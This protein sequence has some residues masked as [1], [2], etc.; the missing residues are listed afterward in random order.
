MSKIVVI[1]GSAGALSAL[2]IILAS[3]P[4]DFPA[5]ILIVTH[6]GANKSLLPEILQRITSLQVRHA[7]DGE[8]IIPGRVLVAPSDEHLTVVAS[9]NQIYTRLAHGPRENNCR[10][11]IDPLFRSAA[12]ACGPGTT[13]VILSGY[14]DD[15][16]VGLQAIKARGGMAIVQDPAEAEVQEM[17]ASAI[18]HATVD[19][20]L[21]ATQIGSA[22]IQLVN[23]DL[24]PRP[25]IEQDWIDIENRLTV[26]DSDMNDLEEIGK[27]SSL[28]CPECGGALWE[29]SRPGPIRYRCHTAHAFTA[30]VLESLQGEEVEDA[31]WA[32]VRALHEQERLFIKMSEKSQQ[33]GH[34]ISSA[35]YLA[36]AE[37]A[38]KHS[39]SLREIIATRALARS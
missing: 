19:L 34:S 1:G 5:A 32:A 26:R 35:E 7:V 6:I 15:G 13:G 20:T 8:L 38:R 2:K 3:L 18:E 24:A 28:T 22:L 30:R 33:L 29:I 11:A 4:E 16:T 31:I 37:Q 23:R 25:P 21:G 10:P 27:P 36:K 12:A 9:G 14:L 39:Q 17:P